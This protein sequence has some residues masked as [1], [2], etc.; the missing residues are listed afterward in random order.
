MLGLGGRWA[1]RWRSSMVIGNSPTIRA[2]LFAAG[3]P[4]PA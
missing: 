1:R 2:S 4:L 3:V